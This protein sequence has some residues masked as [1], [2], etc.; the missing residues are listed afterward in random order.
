MVGMIQLLILNDELEPTHSMMIPMSKSVWPRVVPV[1]L[2]QGQEL[3]RH[4]FLKYH[5]LTN[6]LFTSFSRSAGIRPSASSSYYDSNPI[7][8]ELAGLYSGLKSDPNNN[9]GNIYQNNVSSLWSTATKLTKWRS[10]VQHNPKTVLLLHSRRWLLF[11]RSDFITVGSSTQD[12]FSSPSATTTSRLHPVRTSQ[13]PQEGIDA[14]WYSGS[15]GRMF[16]P[17]STTNGSSCSWGPRCPSRWLFCPE[18]RV[19]NSSYFLS[20]DWRWHNE[21]VSSQERFLWQEDAWYS[22]GC[23]G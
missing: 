4:L 9:S 2:F 22:R 17:T 20:I 8:L 3:V 1:I 12:V 5:V 7:D 19:R 10:T 6:I 16:S 18:S 14:F 11:A 13:Q 15:D 21:G 23:F